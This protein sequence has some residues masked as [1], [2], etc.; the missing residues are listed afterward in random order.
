MTRYCHMA[1]LMTS[2]KMPSGKLLCDQVRFLVP[3]IRWREK[4]RRRGL[5]RSMMLDGQFAESVDKFN[6]RYAKSGIRLES[7]KDGGLQIMLDASSLLRASPLPQLRLL[8]RE[9]AQRR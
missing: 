6:A 4:A 3:A 5:G 9:P 8:L 1:N 2:G 7:G